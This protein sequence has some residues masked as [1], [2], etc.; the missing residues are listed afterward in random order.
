MFSKLYKMFFG[1]K[2]EWS[3]DTRFE[4]YRKHLE[5]RNIPIT[6][7]R[8]ILG[9]EDFLRKATP[10]DIVEGNDLLFYTENFKIKHSDKRKLKQI[11]KDYKELSKEIDQ[12]PRGTLTRPSKS[13]QENLPSELARYVQKKRSQ[14][15]PLNIY[16]SN[17]KK[18]IQNRTRM[19]SIIINNF[20]KETLQREFLFTE[21]DI[22]QV[23]TL[24][25]RAN[26][27]SKVIE[28]LNYLDRVIQIPSQKRVMIA[29][30]LYAYKNKHLAY[31]IQGN[32]P[33]GEIFNRS[34]A[35]EIRNYLIALSYENPR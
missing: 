25:S 18:V 19:L 28:V 24:L 12:I 21:H 34:N 9:I 10:Y 6:D 5:S 2:E 35:I 31:Y 1:S 14:D 8:Y 26:P 30:M 22:D 15:I 13:V 33:Y 16:A 7:Y 27:R 29:I 17:Y 23:F 3:I 4:F 32:S 20:N 11:Y